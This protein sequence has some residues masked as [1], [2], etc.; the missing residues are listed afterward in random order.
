MRLCFSI[1]K[2][3]FWYQ[4]IDFDFEYN[5]CTC[6]TAF[7]DYFFKYEW[8]CNN[9]YNFE[10]YVYN[11]NDFFFNYEDYFHFYKN[12]YM[13]SAKHFFNCKLK[14]NIYGVPLIK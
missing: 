6:K 4:N 8:H 2:Y 14:E 5:L 1:L 12:V 11:T 7:R 3:L 13:S 9:N 10:D